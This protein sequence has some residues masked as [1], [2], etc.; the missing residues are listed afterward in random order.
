[1]SQQ[2]IVVLSYSPVY[3][4]D[5]EEN[6]ELGRISANWRSVMTGL[7]V[8]KRSQQRVERGKKKVVALQIAMLRANLYL[9]SL[10]DRKNEIQRRRRKKKE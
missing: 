7:L 6:I 1:V 2:W 5:G 3:N 4:T 9:D 10:A 8:S